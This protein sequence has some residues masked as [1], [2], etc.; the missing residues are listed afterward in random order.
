MKIS[1]HFY[2]L[3]TIFS[4]ALAF[5]F[6]RLTVVCFSASSQAFIR[7]FIAS[8]TL[9]IIAFISKMKLPKLKDL[10]L[11][12]ISGFFG[13]FVYTQFFN[14]GIASVH[15]SMASVVNATIPI[16]TALVASVL[17]SE[18]IAGKQW[19]G[20]LLEVIGIS[21]LFILNGGLSQGQGLILLFVAA[22]SF[23]IYNLMQ[24]KLTVNYT[25][26]QATTYSIF[27]GTIILAFFAKDAIPELV[28][29]PK[30]QYIYLLILGVFS[31]AIGF[32]T[33]AIAFSKAERTSQVSDYMVLTPVLTSIIEIFMTHTLPSMATIIGGIITIAGVLVFNLSRQK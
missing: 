27:A 31:S 20:V 12:L 8:I 2:A 7:Y 9:L 4:W 10:P 19:I 1:Y 33:W 14:R 5:I 32:F 25:P 22:V 13:F 24:R 11:F 16:M 23:V 21:V 26:L 3:T 18:K 29:A 15:A 30:I 28:A 6:T 17:Y